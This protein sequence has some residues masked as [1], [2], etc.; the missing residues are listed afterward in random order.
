M[1]VLVVPGTSSVVDP[2]GGDLGEFDQDGGMQRR[3]F[4][5]VALAL[6]D[7]GTAISY[8]RQVHV[9]KITLAERKA[10][11][12]VDVAQAYTQWGR[13]DDGLSALRT[14]YRIAPQEIRS[15]PAMHR[16]VTDLA[17]L[18]RGRTRS[19]VLDFAATAGIR[20]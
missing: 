19:Q 14:A 7:A 4:L 6:G 12:F 18:S 13:H 16:I 1:N 17:A 20:Q 9:D 8:A 5:T 10:S 11:L 15:R 3:H 2:D